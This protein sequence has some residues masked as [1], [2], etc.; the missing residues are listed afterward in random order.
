M[1]Y[2]LPGN[3]LHGMLFFYVDKCPTGNANKSRI[4]KRGMENNILDCRFILGFRRHCDPAFSAGE[5][6]CN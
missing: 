5:A 4:T 6:N 2:S 3:Q 1:V